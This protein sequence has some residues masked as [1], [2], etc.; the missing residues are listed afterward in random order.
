MPHV[1]LSFDFVNLRDPFALQ[2]GCFGFRRNNCAY[3]LPWEHFSSAAME[4]GSGEC[5]LE[6][7]HEGDHLILT[8]WGNFYLWR[9]VIC[10]DCKSDKYYGCFDSGKINPQ[11]AVTFLQKNMWAGTALHLQ[12]PSS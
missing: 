5:L 6:E 3:L 7:G 12:T 11:Q 10:K 2:G 8:A 9:D 4:K 1:Q